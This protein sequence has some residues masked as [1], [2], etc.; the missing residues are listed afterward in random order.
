M[1]F[2]F[3]CKERIKEKEKKVT[4]KSPAEEKRK[5]LFVLRVLLFFFRRRRRKRNRW[6]A[7]VER[8]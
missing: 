8:K 1:T 2:D 3:I 5:L 7:G 4:G 6:R